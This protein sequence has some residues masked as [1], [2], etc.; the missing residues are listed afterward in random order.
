MAR[1]VLSMPLDRGSSRTRGVDD[2]APAALLKGVK[3][4]VLTPV[5]PLPRLP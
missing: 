4:L 5:T 2:L 1:V 3:C